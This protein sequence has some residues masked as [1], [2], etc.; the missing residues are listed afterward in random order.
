MPDFQG[1]G[2][3]VNFINKIS[4]FYAENN[5]NVNLI[6]T[7][8]ALIHALKK[9]KN[10]ILIRADRVSSSMQKFFEYYGGQDKHLG[11]TSSQKRVTYSFNFIK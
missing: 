7:T 9:N 2:I 6:T 4:E 10:W 5:Y 11:N 3:G 1:I 8:P